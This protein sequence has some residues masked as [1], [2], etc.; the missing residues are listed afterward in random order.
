LLE[1][2]GSFLCIQASIADYQQY[3]FFK[4]H[5]TIFPEDAAIYFSKI[6]DANLSGTGD[7]YYEAIAE[8]I[9]HLMKINSKQADKYLLD[10]RANYKRR[11]NLIALLEKF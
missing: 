11:R 1:D 5:K 6:I 8:A 3:D 9:R 4:K 10:I 7:H 2:G